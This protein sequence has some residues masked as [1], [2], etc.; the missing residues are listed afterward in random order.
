MC[1]CNH[2]FRNPQRSC[3]MQSGSHNRPRLLLLCLSQRFLDRCIPSRLTWLRTISEKE[4]ARSEHALWT[5]HSTMASSA[6]LTPLVGVARLWVVGL[7]LLNMASNHRV[8]SA[9]AAISKETSKIV[10]RSPHI[11]GNVV[12]VWGY[13]TAARFDTCKY[14]SLNFKN[15]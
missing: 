13:I 8:I 2:L 6:I 11:R 12:D 14:I 1:V 7:R 10:A 5:T 3:W 15:N 4:R 9:A